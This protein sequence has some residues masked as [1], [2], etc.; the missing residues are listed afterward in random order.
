MITVNMVIALAEEYHRGETGAGAAKKKEAID[1]IKEWVT[2]A[3]EERK[4]RPG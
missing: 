4:F 3:V 1:K 2:K